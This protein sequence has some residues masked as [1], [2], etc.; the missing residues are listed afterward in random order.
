MTTFVESSPKGCFDTHIA[1][2]RICA[3]CKN[4][5]HSLHRSQGVEL[6]GTVQAYL[7][8]IILAFIARLKNKPDQKEHALPLFIHLAVHRLPEY[9]MYLLWAAPIWGEGRVQK[10]YTENKYTQCRWK[11][12]PRKSYNRKFHM[13]RRYGMRASGDEQ[14]SVSCGC[15]YMI[16][17]SV[18]KYISYST[19]FPR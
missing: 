6:L 2:R 19:C 8:H 4:Y 18:D 17:G 1:L 11:H 3:V 14:P 12:A 7:H 9:C 10:W 16:F 15:S 13:Y 5:V